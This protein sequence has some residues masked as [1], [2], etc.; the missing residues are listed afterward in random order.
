MDLAGT[1]SQDIL[2]LDLTSFPRNLCSALPC[3]HCLHNAH[4]SLCTW[5]EPWVP[6]RRELERRP[7][8]V[9]QALDLQSGSEALALCVL[10][11][12][13][14]LSDPQFLPL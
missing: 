8:V 1:E 13:L 5:P 7:S 9:G 14:G 11:K 3:S 10:S 12:S 4:P 6:T 2:T